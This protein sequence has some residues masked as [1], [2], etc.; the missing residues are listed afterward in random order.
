MTTGAPP[1]DPGAVRM[2]RAGGLTDAPPTSPSPSPGPNHDLFDT[3]L[4]AERSALRALFPLPAPRA[5]A[6]RG[7]PARVR[8]AG[9]ALAVVA[10]AVAAIVWADPAWR[11]ELHATAVGEQRTVAL[12]DGSRL[13]LDTATGVRVRWHL[14]SRQVELLQGRARFDVAHSTLRPLQVAAGS[15]QV[16]VVGT[17]FDVQRAPHGQVRVAVLQG[18]VQVRDLARAGAGWT[19]D[20]GERLLAG[21]A[22]AA[23]PEPFDLGPPHGSTLGWAQ[24]RLV[25]DRTPLRD[26]LAEV[27]RY[28]AA[29]IRL[30]DD[31]R[32]AQ[33]TVSGVFQSARTDQLLDLLPQVVGARV[34]H[35]PDGSV[36]VSR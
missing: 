14:R 35:R 11:T 31:G 22:H 28:R 10:T 25:F 6:R 29:P 7:A 4:Q 36:D 12:A 27:Q 13:T 17:V 26:A 33:Q 21:G 16:R 30:H 18:R 19:L 5:Q 1:A 20:P 24:G 32:L 8:N 15:V 23:A 34:Q 3:A 9:L 2:L